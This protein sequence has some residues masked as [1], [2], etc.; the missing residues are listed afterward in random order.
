[1]INASLAGILQ[2]ARRHAQFSG[3]YGLTYGIEGALNEELIDLE[4][5]SQETMRRLTYTPGSI[6]GS[7]RHKLSDTDYERIL[8]VFRAHDVRYFAYIGGND[9]MD[10][11]H[12]ISTL[13]TAT[14]YELRVMGVPK[15]ID[16]DLVLTDHTPGYGSAA[17][18]VAL[19]ARDAGR[20]LEAMATFDDVTILETMG[21]NT[22]WL[23]AASVLGK[24]SEN[25]APHL[26]YV[27]EVLFDETRFLE[28]VAQIHSQL[29]R[30]FVVVCEGLRD[31]S[32]QF[33]GQHKLKGSN[34]DAFGH[35]LV[36]LTTGVASYLTS[37]VREELHLQARFLRPALIGRVMSSCV[38]DTDRR[39]A[40]EVGRQAV[41]HLA[42]GQS[43]FMVT[44]E[45]H[46][47]HPYSFGTGLAPLAEVA[48]REKLL[49]RDFL[50]EAGNMVNQAFKDYA[51][52]LIDGP[53]P[54]LARLKGVRVP[55]RVSPIQ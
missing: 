49:P 34:T 4:Q 42:T 1:M 38:A 19:A 54:P 45:R 37:L 24:E 13:A 55:K 16:N 14:G 22:G 51:L 41:A 28:D 31:A 52:P 36:A 53:L 21:R 40:L 15:T 20:D 33:I 29:G 44:L 10:T 9:S 26:V 47:Q 32:G 12:R 48:N 43:G 35:T 25:E 17:Q 5:E 6:L 18:F 7:C 30:V 2:E 3:I 23:A 46:T 11:C 27:P 39:E 8:T 50:N